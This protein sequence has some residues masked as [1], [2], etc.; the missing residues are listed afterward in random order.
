MS[1]PVFLSK[2]TANE[3][4]LFANAS[5]A[6]AVLTVIYNGRSQGWFDLVAFA[7]LPDEMQLVVAPKSLDPH[8]IMNGIQSETMPLL[9]ALLRGKSRI[10]DP[11]FLQST[12]NSIET[13]R[14]QIESV[15]RSPVLLGLSRRPSDYPFCSANP[16]FHSMLDY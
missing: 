15:H 7:V 1:N 9:R 5:C 3:E 13:L 16:R 10:W 14:A 6:E 4:P 2:M 11:R 12:I 8:G